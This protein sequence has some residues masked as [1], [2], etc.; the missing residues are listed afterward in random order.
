MVGEPSMITIEEFIGGSPPVS[1][2]EALAL[3][4]QLTAAQARLAVT[5]ADLSAV[6]IE[7]RLLDIDEAAALL[8]VDRQWLYRRTR[9]V[10][11]VVRLDGAVRFSARGIEQFITARRG[12]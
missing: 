3:M 9:K 5:I 8:S 12:R 2:D 11:F 4:L 1:R 10:P 7:D 6:P